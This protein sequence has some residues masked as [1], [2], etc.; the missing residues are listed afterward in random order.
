MAEYTLQVTEDELARYR[1][2]AANAIADEGDA[3]VAAGVTEGATVLDVG[4]GPAA[5]AA[6]MGHM[7][8]PT[9]RVIGIERA[10]EALTA[11]RQLLGEGPGNVELRQGVAT[12][13]GVEPGSVDVVMMRHVLAHNGGDEQAIVDHLATLPRS[14][15][16]VYLLDV[17]LSAFRV[18]G[19]VDD[20]VDLQDRYVQFHRGRGNDPSV[21]LRLAELARDAGLTDVE[22]RGWF[23]IQTMPP[24]MRGPAWSAR[25]QMLA[26]AVVTEAEIEAW[27]AAF[28]QSDA[29]EKR[30]TVFAAVFSCVARVP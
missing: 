21:G 28:Q 18:L 27:D 1:M 24:G 2:M 23:D 3:F 9:G 4:C 7:V 19:S 16:S 12:D 10:P 8:G 29:D 20:L 14:G 22:H 17:D 30:P 5:I 25:G 11:A 26:D 13:T 6:E 15:G